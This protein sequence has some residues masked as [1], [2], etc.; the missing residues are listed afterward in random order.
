[1][2]TTYNNNYTKGHFHFIMQLKLCMVPVSVTAFQVTVSGMYV[3]QDLVLA[4]NV[5]G[6]HIG[7]KGVLLIKK[8]LIVQSMT[9]RQVQSLQGMDQYSTLPCLGAPVLQEL[10]NT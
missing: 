6:V 8:Q 1:M 10:P 9:M 3:M 5:N 7:S 2:H 4:L